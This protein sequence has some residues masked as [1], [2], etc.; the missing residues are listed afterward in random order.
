ML[1]FQAPPSSY[2]GVLRSSNMELPSAAAGSAAMKAATICSLQ[3]AIENLCQSAAS[4]M[5][6]MIDT[7]PITTTTTTITTM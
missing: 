4:G 2:Q 7:M 1:T 6:M 5:A 3:L